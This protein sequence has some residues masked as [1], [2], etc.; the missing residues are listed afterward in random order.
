MHTNLKNGLMPSDN[1][2]TWSERFF[3]PL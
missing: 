3:Q 2:T 1:T